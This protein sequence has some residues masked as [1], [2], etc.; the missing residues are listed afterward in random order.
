MPYITWEKEWDTGIAVIDRQ[1]R[2]IIELINDLYKV[3]DRGSSRDVVERSLRDLI[4]YTI[5]HFRFEEEL[6]VEVGYPYAKAHKHLHD[7]FANK[8]IRFQERFAAGEDVLMEVADVLEKW[9]ENHVIIDDVDYAPLARKQLFSDG[10]SP[11]DWL[12]GALD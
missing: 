3:R 6:Q 12:A 10:D 11:S 2:R 4:D 8:L 7:V 5:S 9:L 1:H